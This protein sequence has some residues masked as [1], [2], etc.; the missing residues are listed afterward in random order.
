MMWLDCRTESICAMRA[1]MLY[2]LQS[3]GPTSII[4]VIII[5]IIVIIAKSIAV[6]LHL[7]PPH[8]I[9]RS[10]GC[11]HYHHYNSYMS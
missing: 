9:D 3:Q 2:L 4:N 5:I 7:L 8:P 11:C 6:M 10:R 1:G